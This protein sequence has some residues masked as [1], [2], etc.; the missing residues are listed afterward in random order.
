M[1]LTLQAQN[2]AV[3]SVAASPA[4]FT[5]VL[6]A[7]AAGDQMFV[8][9]TSKNETG[10]ASTTAEGWSVAGV[11]NGGGGT[12]GAD[13]GPTKVTVFTKEAASSSETA[14][15]I[16]CTGINVLWY[17]AWTVRATSGDYGIA[18]AGG[19]DSTTGTAWSVTC[20]TNPD[21][22]AGDHVM[23]VSGDPTDVSHTYAS[24]AISATGVSAWG[25]ATIHD[26]P[27]SGTGNDIGGFVFST[28]VTTGTSTDVP[29]VTATVS[30]TTT[31]VRGPSLLVRVRETGG[32]QLA[33]STSD[34]ASATD[35]STRATS[36]PRGLADPAGAVDVSARSSARARALSDTAS[37]SDATAASV[38]RVVA[39]S[40]TDTA[41]AV[42][43]TARTTARSRGLTDTAAAADSLARGS[44]RA[45]MLVDTAVASDS[46]VAGRGVARAQG[47]VVGGAD[48]ATRAVRTARILT[49]V[50]TADDG[51]TRATSAGRA[52]TETAPGDDTSTRVV[53]LHRPL[54]DAADTTDTAAAGTVGQF[55]ASATESAP[56]V[57]QTTRLLRLGAVL[58]DVA[59]GADTTQ[60][61]LLTDRTQ[62]DAAAGADTTAGSTGGGP[63]LPLRPGHAATVAAPAFRAETTV[64]P[65]VV[66]ATSEHR[67]HGRMEVSST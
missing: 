7:H 11:A 13:A 5:P 6:A 23:V 15:L 16:D 56:A 54:S 44:S 18:T 32:A 39:R 61:L 26:Q 50:A 40:V 42:D 37:A 41:S 19:A 38:T 35:T 17:K 9:V 62:V 65:S 24:P 64:A 47:E 29:V 2:A 22:Q 20:T 10:S 27:R 60:R 3:T 59:T 31:N 48:L 1:T 58:A 4:S 12:T 45:R 67:S 66:G 30:G 8:A 34:T 55:A 46:S 49:D 36:L 21:L 52:R 25:A 57:D 53:G 43:V 28:S 63:T 14:P 33:R 51:T